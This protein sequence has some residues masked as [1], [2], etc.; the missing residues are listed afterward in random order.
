MDIVV[1]T[2]NRISRTHCLVHTK[3]Y[4]TQKALTKSDILKSTGSLLSTII[5]MYPGS[6]QTQSITCNKKTIKTISEWNKS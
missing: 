3:K 4:I 1:L 6:S 2:I 5:S